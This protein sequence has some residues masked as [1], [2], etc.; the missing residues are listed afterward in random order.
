MITGVLG[1]GGASGVLYLLLVILIGVVLLSAVILGLILL[2][3]KRKRTA[4][5]IGLV[6]S[7]ATFSFTYHFLKEVRRSAD[8]GEADVELVLLDGGKYVLSIDGMRNY[9]SLVLISSDLDFS[10]L[11]PDKRMLKGGGTEFQLRSEGGTLASI[12]LGGNDFTRNDKLTFLSGL[13]SPSGS[14]AF[15]GRIDE[16]SVLFRQQR[17]DYNWLTITHSED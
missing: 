12:E 5:L 13:D 10:V 1:G 16:Y 2:Y 8:K 17:S 11:L 7:V 9:D 4:V 3:R 6:L 14:K 15:D